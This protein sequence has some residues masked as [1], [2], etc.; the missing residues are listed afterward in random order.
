MEKQIICCDIKNIK[1]GI[2]KT[3]KNVRFRINQ[4]MIELEKGVFI[5]NPIE[6]AK[7]H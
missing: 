2:E 1:D 5:E 7:I 6:S 4:K 3:Y